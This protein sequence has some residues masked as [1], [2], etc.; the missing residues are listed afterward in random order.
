MSIIDIL[1]S[2]V[3]LCIFDYLSDKDKIMACSVNK[4]FREYLNYI[5]F[6]ELYYYDQIKDLFQI[7]Q[8][9]VNDINIP[10]GI[11]HLKLKIITFIHENKNDKTKIDTYYY[12]L[13]IKWIIPTKYL[14]LL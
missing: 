7:Y 2:D 9:L 4:Y 11:T 5:N 13:K 1:N 10:K 12:H 14:R 3:L 8:Y 6:N